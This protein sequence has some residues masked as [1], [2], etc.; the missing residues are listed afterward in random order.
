MIKTIQLT[1]Q[2]S[3][4]TVLNLPNL[5]INKGEAFGLVGNNGAGKTDLRDF[6]TK[7]MVG[8]LDELYDKI[9]HNI[10]Y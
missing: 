10:D 1:K 6:S 2:Y 9:C 7:V 5:T 4:N 3:G 8:K